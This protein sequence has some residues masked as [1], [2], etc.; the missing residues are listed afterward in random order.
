MCLSTCNRTELYLAGTRRRG[1]RERGRGAAGGPCRAST[2]ACSIPPSTGCGTR[3]PRSISSASLPVSIRSSRAKPRSSGRFEARSRPAHRTGA[4]PPVPAGAPCRQEG[5]H[6]DRDR[7]EPGVGL[8]G[9]CRAGGAGV[10]RPVRVASAARGRREG[11][12]A[13]RPEALG[14]RGARI[15]FVA[16]RSRRRR[17][18]GGG[19]PRRGGSV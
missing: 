5:A 2:P 10:R 19:V 11:R 14:S 15:A 8:V 6:R 7:R 13:R 4:R 17:R 3:R 9:R 18:R 1:R 16:S 12:G